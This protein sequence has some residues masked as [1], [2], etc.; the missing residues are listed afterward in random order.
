MYLHP[1][2]PHVKLTRPGAGSTT[3]PALRS[4][5]VWL[6]LSAL[7]AE[8]GKL[9]AACTGAGSTTMPAL[10]LCVQ[11]Q[12]R[13]GFNH[14]VITH[15][16]FSTSFN[17]GAGWAHF[18]AG[19]IQTQHTPGTAA[20]AAAAADVEVTSSVETTAAAAGGGGGGNSEG[21]S[22]ITPAVGLR[23]SGSWYKLCET[24]TLPCVRDPLTQQV[25]VSC[26]T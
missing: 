21:P 14:P 7:T 17:T 6:I 15:L 5:T 4:N 11:V 20:A 23:G 22:S 1:P 25:R 12:H 9:S 24:D 10:S 16:P 8:H 26:C 13:W 2:P 3:T 19:Q 18:A